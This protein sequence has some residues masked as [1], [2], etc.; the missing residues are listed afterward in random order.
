MSAD[1]RW[2]GDPAIGWRILL[3]ARLDA[4]PDPA[5]VATRLAALYAEE[6]W[7]AVPGPEPDHDVR[8]LQA[9][10]T[11]DRPEPVLVG[12]AEGSVVVSAHHSR[13]DGLGL[14]RVLGATIGAPVRSSARGVGGRPSTGGVVGTVAERLREVVVRPPAALDPP[15]TLTRGPGH[16]DGPDTLAELDVEGRFRTA[17]LVHAAAGAAV[18]HQRSL[19]LRS[20]PVAVAVGATREGR[21]DGPIADASV[22]L[23]LRDVER[24]DRD[25]VAA[26]LRSAPVQTPPAVRG[27]LGRT[28]DPLLRAGT[29]ALSRRLGSTLLVS[30]L[31]DVTAPAS[32]ERLAFHPVT[33]GGSGVSLGAVALADGARTVLTLRARSDRWQ[34]DGLEQV[35]EAIAGRLV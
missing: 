7:G 15:T 33:A 13:V 35:L 1:P 6:G 26:A 24:L 21:P 14:L 8:R 9:R 31:G 25:Q 4:A 23:R 22:L 12:T 28:V 11:A 17:D 5:T 19:G 3:T 20:E 30:H 29:R 32:V 27:P 16:A 10:L 2:V 18:A 34:D